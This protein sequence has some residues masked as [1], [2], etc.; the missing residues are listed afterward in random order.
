MSSPSLDTC[1]VGLISSQFRAF[2]S[3]YDKISKLPADHAAN[4]IGARNFSEA[5]TCPSTMID[6]VVE[7]LYPE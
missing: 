3:V 1:G 5:G 7:G 2:L 4:P 6:P